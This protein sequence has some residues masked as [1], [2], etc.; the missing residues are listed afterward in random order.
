M[1][2]VF[3]TDSFKRKIHSNL[4]IYNSYFNFITNHTNSEITKNEEDNKPKS[5]IK[6]MFHSIMQLDSKGEK[7]TMHSWQQWQ[8]TS[9]GDSSRQQQRT[10]REIVG[11]CDVGDVNDDEDLGKAVVGLKLFK[12]S[13]VENL[14]RFCGRRAAQE[15][16]NEIETRVQKLE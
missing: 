16:E 10:V 8:R 6:D 5:E 7:C 14:N 1:Q 11:Q 15:K 9:G 13:K 12:L 3:I 4:Y 2:T